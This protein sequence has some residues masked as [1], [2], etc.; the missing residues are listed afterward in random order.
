ME[1]RGQPCGTWFSMHTIW[2]LEKVP[3]MAELPCLTPAQLIFLVLTR[4]RGYCFTS[5]PCKEKEVE[6]WLSS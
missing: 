1:A 3:L 2:V 4:M 6:T 5:F